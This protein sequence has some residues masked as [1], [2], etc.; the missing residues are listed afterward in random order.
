MLVADPTT[1]QV[2]LLCH[3]L[4]LRD[5]LDELPASVLVLLYK[6]DAIEVVWDTGRVC[7]ALQ[8]RSIGKDAV[9]MVARNGIDQRS[10][11]GRERRVDRVL[12]SQ[13]DLQPDELAVN[14]LVV[15]MNL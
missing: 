2:Q 6:D 15:L 3:P 11:V 9:C 7:L 14:Y 8:E 1:S 4:L 13:D 5:P 10:R 12:D